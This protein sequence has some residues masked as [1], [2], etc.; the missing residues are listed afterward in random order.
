MVF[1]LLG[2]SSCENDEEATVGSSILGQSTVSG[3]I[4]ANGS[5]TSLEAALKIAS[6]ELPE[7]LK[8]SGPFTLFAPNNGAFDALAAEA[9]FETSAALLADIDP[10]LLEKILTYHV[11][12]GKNSAGDLSEG[13]TLTTV[14]GDE[15]TVTV[16][17]NGT[18]QLL[19]ASK[20]PQTNPV[21]NV[22]NTN[23][24]AAN[25]IVHF[26]DKV[27]LPQEAIEALN[28]DIRPSFLDWGKTIEDLS[29]LVKALDK[30]GLEDVIKEL[31]SATV[32]A[33]TDQAIEGLFEELG[34]DYNS[35]EDFD[36]ETEIALLRD[37][38]RYHI[39]PASAELT[40]GQVETAL[41]GSTVGVIAVSGGFAF[42][43][44]TSTNA[45]TLTSDIDAKNGSLQIIDKVLLPQ[46]V[47]DFKATLESDDL[48]TVVA[49]ETQLSKLEQALIA[50]ELVEAFADATNQSFIQGEDEKDEDFQKRSTPS[51]Y[52]YFKPA[53]VFAPTNTAFNDLFSALGD[54]YT[55]IDS[56]DT[57][58]E[59][60]LLKEILL[61][62]VLPSKVTST[63]LTAGNVTT[64]AKSDIEIIASVGNDNFVIGDATNDV[65]ANIVTSDIKAR[66]GVAHIV[67]KVLLPESAIAF[68]LSLN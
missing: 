39:L 49:N 32:L 68:I 6:G 10:A 27:L 17:G 65:N 62:H 67:D 41:E 38:M 33:P 42:G 30:V 4:N 34:D 8:G 5:L 50:T 13:T 55:G 43:D 15:V 53:T 25:G 36:N 64:A 9:G 22:T 40:A 11:V 56:F 59:L 2:L 26:I 16:S 35:L 58:D 52:T 44:A 37:I 19:D 23:P 47:L 63:D 24:D 1:A 57:E 51:N 21:S 60:A 31:E 12:A 28:I 54:E 48:T 7:T 29:L 3:I 18:I 14:L 66:N 20:L 46:T 45:G 61:Y